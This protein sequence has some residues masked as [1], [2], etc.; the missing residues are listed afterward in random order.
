MLNVG[1]SPI[2]K[3]GALTKNMILIYLLIIVDL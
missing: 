2:E 1:Q 3:S